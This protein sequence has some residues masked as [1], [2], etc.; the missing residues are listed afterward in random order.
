[1]PTSV[2]YLEFPTIPNI[3]S[4]T[5]NRSRSCCH[6][7]LDA[8]TSQLVSCAVWPNWVGDPGRR[9]AL[10][11]MTSGVRTYIIMRNLEDIIN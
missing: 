9:V 7:N 4:K 3:L 1:M 2:Q 11:Q 6:G 10:D 8:Y 5:G